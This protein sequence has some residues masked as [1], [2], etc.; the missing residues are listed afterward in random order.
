MANEE[1]KLALKKDWDYF[2][3]YEKPQGH[4]IGRKEE[5]NKIE[6]WFIRREKGCLLVS[7]ERGVGKTALV[8]EALY[9]ATAKNKKIIPVLI[10]AS[11]LL[12]EESLVEGKDVLEIS[13]ERL[14]EKIIINLIR[15]LYTAARGK[16]D[17]DSQRKLGKL[18]QKAISDKSEIKEE[19]K[20]KKETEQEEKDQQEIERK[21]SVDSEQIRNFLSSLGIIVGMSFFYLSTKANL[22]L[23]ILLGSLFFLLPKTLSYKILKSITKSKKAS[24]S[25]SIEELYI[26]DKSISNLEYDLY[27][28]LD[29]ISLPQVHS[30]IIFVIDEM[31]KIKETERVKITDIIKTFKNLFTLSSGLF[32]FIAGKDIYDVVEK[33]K[34]EREIACTFFNDKIFI[35]RPNFDDLEKYIDEIIDESKDKFTNKQIYQ[36]FRNL[37]CYQAKSDFFELHFRIR[38]YISDYDKEDRPVLQIES[39][40]EIE[41]FHANIQKALGQIFDLNKYWTPS[42]WY[43]NNLLLTGLYKFIDIPFFQELHLSKEPPTRE[44]NLLLRIYLAQ[45]NLIEY[46]LRLGVISLKGEIAKTIEGK[47]VAFYAYTW[48]QSK[49]VVPATPQVLLDYENRFLENLEK[50][51]LYVNQVDDTRILVKDGKPDEGYDETKVHN[52]DIQQYCDMDVLTIYQSNQKYLAKLQKNIPQHIPREELENQTNKII[53][54][55]EQ[56]KNQII[57]I[58]ERFFKNHVQLTNLLFTT[59]PTDPNLFGSTMASIREDVI[60]NKMPHL[61]FYRKIPK[62]SRQILVIKDMPEKHYE[63]HKNMINENAANYLIINLN[64][65]G[66]KYNLE[67]VQKNKRDR[68][69][70]GFIDI[71]IYE[72]FRNL[73]KVIEEIKRRDKE[74][75]SDSEK[76]IFLN[77]AINRETLKVYTEWKFLDK[78]VSDELNIKILND[79][80]IAKYSKLKDID[81]VIEKAKPAVDAYFKEKPDWFKFGTDFITKSLGFV[82]DAFL[83]KHPFAQETRDA[84]KRL[85][86]LIEI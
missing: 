25:S 6:N 53:A 73:Q 84:V 51:S 81:D 23:N 59:L 12:I 66:A 39:F 3:H 85:R 56:F 36:D 22:V 76:D 15:R 54:Y 48:T 52:N 20:L 37:L 78:P 18:Y 16:L 61:C 55:I 70:K 13:P 50:F 42:C 69:I 32:V 31:D 82:D 41:L 5:R 46:L 11:Q 71:P 2:P 67:F 26:T 57:I 47:N 75:I 40:E 33:S 1:L 72:S 49:M 28:L 19:I 9:K 8:Y 10:N 83:V 7:G 45:N 77:Q 35:S 29:E 68:K 63:S 30:K 86:K 27:A 17:D 64:T 79:I 43:Q 38:D 74:I 60:N 80:D 44:D 4:F 65:S 24:E 58:I 34:E 14:E 62:Y 21:Y